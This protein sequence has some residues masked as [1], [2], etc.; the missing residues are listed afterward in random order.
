MRGFSRLLSSSLL[1]CG[2][3]LAVT[4]FDVFGQHGTPASP[5]TAPVVDENLQRLN[6]AAS[7]I[8]TFYRTKDVAGFKGAFAD[9]EAAGGLELGG[10]RGALLGFFSEFFKTHPELLE[11]VVYPTARWSA[12]A[13]ENLAY[14]VVSSRVPTGAKILRDLGDPEAGKF[15]PQSCEEFGMTSPGEL[16]FCWGY[17]FATGD[18]RAI[19]KI[20][21][22]LAPKRPLSASAASTDA[23]PS[24]EAKTMVYN[25]LVAQAAM[26]SL[27]SNGRN[28]SEV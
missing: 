19:R 24:E 26:W 20:V 4:P 8:Q 9:L 23:D 1:V 2:V 14:I 7:W 3:F 11:Q 17:F 16:D 13:K 27:G 21:T 12:D 10:T 15:P 25:V 18:T 6:R 5:T 28:Y 22:A